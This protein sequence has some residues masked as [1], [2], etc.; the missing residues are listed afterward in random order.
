VSSDIKATKLFADSIKERFLNPYLNHLLTSISLNSISKWRARDLPS[1]KDYYKTNGIIPKYLTIGFS[2]LMAIYTNIEKRDD[3]YFVKLPS[4]EI[5]F[6]D[7]KPYLDYFASNGSV[8]EFMKD[9]NV[10]GEDL[11]KYKNFYESVEENLDKIRK[12]INLL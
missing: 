8:K 11:T 2:Y 5:S 7:D 6:I 1:F 12:G 3:K 4:R 9:V 10:W